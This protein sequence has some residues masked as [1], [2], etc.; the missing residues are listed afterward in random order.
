VDFAEVAI[1]REG[2]LF[3]RPIPNPSDRMYYD[4]SH[5][6]HL[7]VDGYVALSRYRLTERLMTEAHRVAVSRRDFMIDPTDRLY[8]RGSCPCTISQETGQ[9]YNDRF[10][11]DKELGGKKRS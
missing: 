6:L 5:F 10:G 2:Q 8:Y 3:Y 1:N 4:G 7:V 11:V 9:T